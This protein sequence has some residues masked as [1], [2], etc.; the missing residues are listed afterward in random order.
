[1]SGDAVGVEHGAAPV[2]TWVDRPL[3]EPWWPAGW[4]PAPVWV[5]EAAQDVR[6]VALGA[7]DG[8]QAVGASRRGRLHAHRGAAREDA[9][10]LA[11]VGPLAVAVVADGA[12]SRPLSRIGA[13][14]ACRAATEA[15]AARALD[16]VT[17]DSL[18]AALAA[19]LHRAGDALR[20][21]AAAHGAAPADLRTTLLVGVVA[22][23]PQ[24]SWLGAAQIGDGTVAVEATDGSVRLL[25]AGD[26]GAFAGEVSHFLPDAGAAEH[27]AA[28]VTVEPLGTAR[29]LLLCSDGVDDCFYPIPRLGPLMLAQ[30]REGVTEGA[31]GFVQRPSGP[32]LRADDPAAALA[33]WLSYEKRGENDDRTLALLWQEAR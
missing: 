11:R 29:A 18:R 10:E 16:P 1:V 15:L 2:P 13:A 8:W 6:Q 9:I 25:T 19:A 30:L 17:A 12:G 21:L 22:V 20:T 31:P 32:V 3:A 23:A 28:R 33:E 26:S 4:G 27:G 7:A 5:P 14:L 24:G